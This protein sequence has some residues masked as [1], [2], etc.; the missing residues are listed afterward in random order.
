MN[1]LPAQAR[2]REFWGELI[3]RKEKGGMRLNIL[4]RGAR[5]RA[6]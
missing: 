4:V 3:I 6:I 5:K 2:C 1:V